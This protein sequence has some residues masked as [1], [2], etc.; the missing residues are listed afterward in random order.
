MGRVLV[1]LLLMMVS[2]YLQRM[3][4]ISSCEC[5]IKSSVGSSI[6][7]IIVFSCCFLATLKWYFVILDF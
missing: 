7:V 5:L 2:Q 4:S 1:V 6:W 3:F